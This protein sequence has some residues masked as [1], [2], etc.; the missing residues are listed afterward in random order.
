MK[1]LK[2]LSIAV[3]VV[4]LAS[5]AGGDE[6]SVTLKVEAQLG[7]LTDYIKV[8]DQEVVVTMMDEKVDGE[9]CKVISASLALEVTKSVASDTYY[10]FD[11]EVLDQNHV[12]IGELPDFR[13][14]S[15]YDY[16]N[17]LS[18]VL[19]AGTVRAQMKMSRAV[20]KLT[21]DEQEAWEKKWE[22]ICKEGVYIVIKPNYSSTAKY[23]EYNGKSSKTED[24]E[25]QTDTELTESSDSTIV[26]D[27]TEDNETAFGGSSSSS[28]DW[29]A[30]LD[31]Y[32]KCADK[33]IPYLKKAPKGAKASTALKE[34]ASL[35]NEADNLYL[36]MAF[37][38]KMTTSQRKR[39]TEITNK[40]QKA[41]AHLK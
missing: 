1:V 4:S 40:I 33:L 8:K 5:C 29:D 21:P 15:T 39:F 10:S 3:L 31:S 7:P 13:I 24:E 9:D 37:N 12:K 41:G 27:K 23:A 32:E 20:A 35:M 11:V 2:Y 22:K 16:D 25:A 18:N 30:M 34:C 14:E 36:E 38:T 28:E 6:N 17:D 19:H 26:E